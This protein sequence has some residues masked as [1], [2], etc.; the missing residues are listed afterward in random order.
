MYLAFDDFDRDQ[1]P[2]PGILNKRENELSYD[3]MNS[4]IYIYTEQLGS[5]PV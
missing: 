4:V 3:E 1:D 2:R 5:Y